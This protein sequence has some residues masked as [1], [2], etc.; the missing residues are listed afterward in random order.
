MR[1]SA[2]SHVVVLL[3]PAALLP[4]AA[5][6]LSRVAPA[7][8]PPVADAPLP[9]AAAAPLARV[10]DGLPLVAAAPLPLGEAFPALD[11]QAPRSRDRPGSLLSRPRRATRRWPTPR[12]LHD[13]P[14]RRRLRRIAFA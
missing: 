8:L 10:A 11:V 5:A 2:R 9:L 7:L 12:P 4:R 14:L 13:E 6:G 1:A 3:L